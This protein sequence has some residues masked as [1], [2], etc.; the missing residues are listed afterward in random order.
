MELESLHD[1]KLS[2]EA[3]MGYFG[4]DLFVGTDVWE[5]YGQCLKGAKIFSWKICFLL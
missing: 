5:I 1:G 4:R 3:M 2:W